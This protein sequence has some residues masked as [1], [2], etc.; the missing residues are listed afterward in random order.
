MSGLERVHCTYAANFLGGEFDYSETLG[1][2]IKIVTQTE[3]LDS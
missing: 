3:F 2:Q 1:N